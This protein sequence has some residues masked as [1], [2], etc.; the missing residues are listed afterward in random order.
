MKFASN[1]MEGIKQ[2]EGNEK[3]GLVITDIRMPI[4]NG[5]DVARKIRNSPKPET[6]IV[7]ITGSQ[8]VQEIERE[9]FN[10]ILI[11][12]FRLETLVDVIKSFM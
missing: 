1:G 12:P 8:F 10:S 2:F 11:K 6:P 9:L 7:A 5:N 4:M 3:L